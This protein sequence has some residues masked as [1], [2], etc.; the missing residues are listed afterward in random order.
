[1]AYAWRCESMVSARAVVGEVVVVVVV[2]V[3]VMGAT[4]RHTG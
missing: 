4:L 2:S 3:L 1:M